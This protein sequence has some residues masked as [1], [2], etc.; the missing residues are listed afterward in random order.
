MK[1]TAVIIAGTWSGARLIVRK[2]KA[3]VII[4]GKMPQNNTPP[5][6]SFAIAMLEE[7]C[8]R[9]RGIG[10]IALIN[11]TGRALPYSFGA[12]NEKKSG[13][14]HKKITII[15]TDADVMRLKTCLILS[16]SPA[17]V[18]RIIH[19][20]SAPITPLVRAV[21]ATPAE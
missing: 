8:A 18:R 5:T 15:G 17:R 3:S 14:K 12:N 9:A 21:N 11:N 6:L 2:F 4:A 10:I 7:H 1:P 19:G 13:A 16:Y 20:E